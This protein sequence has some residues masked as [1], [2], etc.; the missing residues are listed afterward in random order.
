[1]NNEWNK[2]LLKSR[3][4]NN[5]RLIKKNKNIDIMWNNLL[6]KQ[7]NNLQND[8]KKEKS[9][10]EYTNLYNYLTRFILY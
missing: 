1:M 3:E 9:K 8:K 7:I 2:M 4:E 5:K 10:E 6:N